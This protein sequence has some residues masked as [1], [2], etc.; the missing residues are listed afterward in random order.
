MSQILPPRA[1]DAERLRVLT[2]TTLLAAE[3]AIIAVSVLALAWAAWNDLACRLIPD[4]ASVAIAGIGAVARLW[5]GPA[6]FGWS[7]LC[8]G[9]LFA[10]LLPMFVR[11]LMGGGDVK[12]LTALALGQPPSGCWRIVFATAMAGGVLAVIHLALRPRSRPA[13]APHGSATFLRVL[14]LEHWRMF[15]RFSLPYGVAIA[16]GGCWVLLTDA[17]T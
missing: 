5:I 10:I 15:R 2:E 4:A 13:L 3:A 17:G 14:R 16:V 8:A 11:G 6:A 9:T 12:L 1:R 7:L